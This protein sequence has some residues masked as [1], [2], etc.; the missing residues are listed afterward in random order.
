[1]ARTIGARNKARV[2]ELTKEARNSGIA[3]VGVYDFVHE[4]LP[5]EVY[6]T[7]ESAYSEIDRIIGDNHNPHI[8]NS[9]FG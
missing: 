9:I 2:I 4:H 7:W 3:G 6:N 5:D 1:M 8:N